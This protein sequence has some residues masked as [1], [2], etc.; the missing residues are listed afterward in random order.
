MIIIVYSKN[1]T[2]HLDHLETALGRYGLKPRPKKCWLFQKEVKFMGHIVSK[3]VSPDP[4]KVADWPEHC[5]AS[6]CISWVCG[7]LQALHTGLCKDC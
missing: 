3:G 4:D 7:L 5:K 6:L 2:E 1:F